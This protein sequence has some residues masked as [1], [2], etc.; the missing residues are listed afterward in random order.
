MKAGTLLRGIT[1]LVLV[2]M[3]ALAINYTS[4]ANGNWGS[5]STWSPPGI[6]GQNDTA[7]INHTVTL[8]GNNFI[9]DINIGTGTFVCNSNYYLFIYG[10]WTN[11]G[12]A[13][14]NSGYAY[15]QGSTDASIG[16]SGPTTFHRLYISKNALTTT[17][18]ME[19]DVTVSYAG[20]SALVIFV[21]T[22]S[23]N[24]N[25]LSVNASSA[26]VAGNGTMNGKLDI[27][28]GGTATLYNLDQSRD[29]SGL[30]NVAIGPG[31][32]VNIT[33]THTIG[34]SGTYNHA[35]NI[36]GG[37]VNYN[38]TGGTYNVLLWIPNNTS[39]G[40]FATGGTTT[41]HGSIAT[42]Y[43]GA[44]SATDSAVVI[45][46]GSANSIY[47]TA[48]NSSGGG[49][50]WLALH[51]FSDLRIQKTGG[52]SL[53]FE[54][55][56]SVYMRADLVVASLTVDA[57]AELALDQ[58][59]FGAGQGYDFGDVTNNGTISVTPAD[60]GSFMV[61]GDWTGTGS[62]VH[63]GKT[64]T[65]DGTASAELDP[66]TGS[67]WD[68]VLDKTG[69]DTLVVTGAV[70][71]EDSL[72]VASGTFILGD[73]LTLGH[74]SDGGTDQGAGIVHVTGDFGG[75]FYAD[76][77]SAVVADNIAYPYEFTVDGTFG[78]KGCHF[79]GM[80]ASEGVHITST[81]MV[82]MVY[83]FEYCGFEHGALT[84]AMLKV[85][86]GQNLDTLVGLT[87]VG[88]DGYNIEKLAASGH[89]TVLGDG[90]S[91]WGEAFDNDPNDLVDWVI[92]YA[93][94]EVVSISSPSGTYQLGDVVTPEAT[95]RNNSSLAVDFEAWAIL[96]EPGGG[97][98]YSEKVDVAGLT[99]GGS[100]MVG[101]FPPCTLNTAGNWTVRCST[102]LAGDEEPGNDVMAR[103]FSVGAVDAGIVSILAPGSFVDTAATVTPSARIRNYSE[104]A[105]TFD[106]WM[107]IEDE[108]DAE[109]YRYSAAV[110]GLA[111][112]RDAGRGVGGR[113]ACAPCRGCGTR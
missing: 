84:G 111:G 50:G 15:F 96:I 67:F 89:V 101:S 38:A 86:N 53:T 112:G 19:A 20:P 7:N 13:T 64:V 81:G 40:W 102:Y 79:S 41:F 18:T 90:G 33:R 24:G 82:D 9:H 52:T 68:V 30:G 5:T 21:G 46:T 75:G 71:V 8:D 110:S 104:Y 66:G 57:G 29:A 54:P 23:T 95:W 72:V 6:P 36:S 91:R 87:F 107:V 65:F 58:D 74:T 108:T 2:A 100:I 99:P 63:G 39:C 11:N 83:G 48:Q 12:T 56:G 28:T 10:N 88:S 31:T 16:G 34:R 85:E 103:G 77:G 32:T 3:P 61:S 37:T 109:L 35:C 70:T 44:F 73:T 43:S 14:W 22:L 62:F 106:A 113:L 25:D 47:H 55:G 26:S 49:S 59:Y 76:T 42:T 27:N 4:A 78:A 45:F 51:T 105:M 94:V 97:T 17:L 80:G 93:D 98:V 69:G 60:N 92:P 1:V